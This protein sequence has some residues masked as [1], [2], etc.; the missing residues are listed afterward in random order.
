MNS[1][2]LSERMKPGALG[3]WPGAP[4]SPPVSSLSD[5]TDRGFAAAVKANP[6]ELRPQKLR[7]V[8]NVNERGVW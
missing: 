8:V 3:G 7:V 5:R 2:P 6:R 1:G 4:M